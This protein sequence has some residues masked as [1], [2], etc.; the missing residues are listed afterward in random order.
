MGNPKP[1]IFRADSLTRVN[2]ATSTLCGVHNVQCTLEWAFF[3]EISYLFFTRYYDQPS[4]LNESNF[5]NYMRQ[6]FSQSFYNSTFWWHLLLMF[7][8]FFL[9]GIKQCCFAELTTLSVESRQLLNL[10]PE[11]SIAFC[12]FS[13]FPDLSKCSIFRYFYFLKK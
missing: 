5:W 8:F 11:L 10:L 4:T 12:W 6:Y 3:G 1:R 7:G 2:Q 9:N 13:V